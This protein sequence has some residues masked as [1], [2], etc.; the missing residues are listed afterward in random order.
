LG[1]DGIR[2][3]AAEAIRKALRQQNPETREAWLQAADAPTRAALEKTE[4]DAK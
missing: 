3:E 2:A 4:A 1:D